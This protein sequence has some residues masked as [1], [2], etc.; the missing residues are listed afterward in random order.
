M[1]KYVAFPLLIGLFL[2][3][4]LFK[5]IYVFERMY[6]CVS[7]SSN[8]KCFLSVVNPEAVLHVCYPRRCLALAPL[9]NNHHN[10]HGTKG[11]DHSCQRI[12][13]H[14]YF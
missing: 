9:D 11:L 6:S 7:L 3:A 4:R 10:Y 5:Y 8:F 1:S 14:R 12:K 2:L 13:D